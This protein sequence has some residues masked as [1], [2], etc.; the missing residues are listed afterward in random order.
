[1][2]NARRTRRSTKPSEWAVL[3]LHGSMLPL[4]ER[5]IRDGAHIQIGIGDYHYAELGAPTNA[6]LVSRIAEIAKRLGRHRI[7]R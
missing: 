2:H 6:D 4:A 7:A 3:N 5:I 1:M